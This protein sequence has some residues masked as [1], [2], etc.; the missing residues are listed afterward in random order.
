MVT[1][2]ANIAKAARNSVVENA[3]GRELG[4]EDRDTGNRQKQSK[5]T[6]HYRLG[7]LACHCDQVVDCPVANKPDELGFLARG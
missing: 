6:R 2:V 5:R 4:K 7:A 3:G 1:P